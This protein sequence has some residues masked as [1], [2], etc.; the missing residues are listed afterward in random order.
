MPQGT[1]NP[2]IEP[3][4]RVLVFAAVFAL[5]ALWEVLAPCRPLGT[6]RRARWPGNLGILIADIFLVRLLLPTAAVGAAV[7][8]AEQHFGLLYVANAPSWL[9]GVVGFIVLDLVIY[10]QHVVFHRVP[11]L[12]RLHRVHH[13]DLDVDVTTGLRFHPLEILLSLIIKMTAIALI[14]IPPLAVLMFEIVLNATSMFNH[15]NASLPER[16]DRVLRLVL[17]TPDM[18]RVH[19]SIESAETDS[20]FGFNLPWWDRVFGTYR[21]ASKAGRLGMTVGLT[22]FRNPEE[23]RFDRLLTQPFREDQ[24]PRRTE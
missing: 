15:A 7:L 11:L 20:N 1:M 17:V 14:G 12:W 8:A 9:A 4:A 23:L 10:L 3:L 21:A 19:H 18:H 16:L 2:I 6:G 13:A 5:M 24:T 22:I